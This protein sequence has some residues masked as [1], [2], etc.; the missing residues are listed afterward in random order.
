MLKFL[1]VLGPG[2]MMAM[3][4]IGASHIIFAPRAGAIYGFALLWVVLAAHLFKY[5]GF[6]FGPRYAVA[7]GQSLLQGYARIPGPKNWAVYL[8]LI[9]AVFIGIAAVTG[10]LSITAAIAF[11]GYPEIPMVHWAALLSS[12]IIAMLIIGKYQ[13]LERVNK[14]MILIL[15]V[16]TLLVFFHTLPPP[17]SLS[18]FFIPS[19]PH[20]SG[21]L[22]LAL[23]GWLPGEL[24]I[25]VL[26]SFW[27]LEKLPRWKKITS[28]KNRLMSFALLDLRIGFVITFFLAAVFMMLGAMI[29]HPAGIHPEG[30][31]VAIQISE[32]YKGIGAWMF[33]VFIAT[34][35]FVMFSTTLNA[36]DGASRAFAQATALSRKV[37]K[38]KTIYT[39]FLC[40]LYLISLIFIYLIPH[41]VLL[42]T[43]A[44]AL[45]MVL[46]PVGYILNLYCV[47]R[48]TPEKFKPPWYLVALAIAGIVFLIVSA[49]LILILAR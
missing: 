40:F 12:L 48:L 28:D 10:V 44:A 24:A 34:A 47:T 16:G 3:I 38:E 19:I 2:I 39:I 21:L 18:S 17:E 11:A 31:E 9:L 4:S 27:V 35:F 29:L 20:G 26:H 37:R 36:M 15:I 32:I 14:L 33:P 43:L 25:S 41:P 6:D 7:T 46:S 23:I 30:V 13:F 8:M 42:V 5:P 22:L 45:G 49:P 1:R